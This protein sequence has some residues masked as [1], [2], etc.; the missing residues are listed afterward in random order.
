MNVGVSCYCFNAPLGA[1]DV[2][3]A[4]VI[5]FVGEQTEADC[6]EPLTR[7]WAPDVPVDEQAEQARELI[8]SVGLEVSCYT[9][10]SDFAVYD[11]ERHRQCVETSIARLRTAQIL[12][13]DTVRLDPRSSLP[14][15]PEEAD[16]N[17]VITRI[18]AGMAEVAD[19]AAELGMTVGVENHGGLLGRTEQ[20]ARMVELV[21]RPNFGVNI[22]PTNFR[23]VYGED[24]VA[25]TRRLAAH[26]VHV[27]AK[28][29]TISPEPRD[30]DEWRRIPTGEYVR[31]SIGGA[32]DARWAQMLG[33][34]RDAGFDGTVSLEISLPE[35][36]KG[37][38]AAGVANLRRLIA[39]L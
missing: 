20:V 17:D 27:H 13:T 30:G 4:E 35:D 8:D 12:G 11:A 36:M 1:G 26:V 14:C 29:F 2:S 31:R 16:V 5:R 3:L 18:S 19:A 7:Y 24:H 39:A 10:D 9:L 28:D 25:A 15:R 21:D 22:D 6:I 37:S 23:N 33:I 34:L 32:G 38:V